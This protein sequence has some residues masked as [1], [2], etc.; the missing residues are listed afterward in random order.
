MTKTNLKN[1]RVTTANPHSFQPQPAFQ[2]LEG[3]KASPFHPTHIHKNHDPP[4]RQPTSR[5]RKVPCLLRNLGPLVP[6][7][8]RLE[9][10]EIPRQRRIR[11]NR[12]LGIPRRRRIRTALATS[13]RED[14][15]ALRS[16]NAA[17]G[18]AAKEHVGGGGDVGED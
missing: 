15:P 4:L 12:P 1:S 9:R 11:R 10:H 13:R 8:L 18:G 5:H 14:V 7:G 6:S 2:T 16:G 3:K 17:A